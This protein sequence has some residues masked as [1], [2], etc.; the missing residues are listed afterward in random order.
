MQLL[1]LFG[2]SATVCSA[3]GGRVGLSDAFDEK[4]LFTARSL[5]AG[6]LEQL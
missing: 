4:L 2:V 3:L 6:M 1:A 5:F